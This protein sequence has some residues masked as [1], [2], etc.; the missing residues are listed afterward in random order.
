MSVLGVSGSPLPNSNT[1]RALRTVL[2]ATGLDTEVI[3]LRDYAVE[4][5][6]ACLG[7]VK[8]NVCVIG[9]LQLTGN[10][11]CVRCGSGDECKM[12]GIKL[13]YGPDA[14]TDTVGIRDFEQQVMKLDEAKPLGAALAEALGARN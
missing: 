10:V 3:K 1:D 12:S 11:P 14:T 4:P 5:C 9:A 2:K 8:T 13:V 7:C 6:R